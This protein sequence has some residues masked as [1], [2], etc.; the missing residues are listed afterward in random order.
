MY[1]MVYAPYGRSG[2]YMIQDYCRKLGVGTSKEE[3]DA[4]TVMLKNLPQ[5]HPLVAMFRGAREAL[6]ADALI[7]ALLNP[8]DRAYSVP[9]L[10][11]FLDRN[12]LKLGRWYWQ[13]AYL[14]QCGTFGETP[15]APRVAALPEHEQYAVMELWRG[16][17]TIHSLVVHRKDMSGDNKVCFDDEQYLKYL[18]IRLPWTI[19]VQD[20]LPPGAAGALVNQTHVFSDLFVMLDAP[21]K[22]LFDAIDGR[23]TIAEIIEAVPGSSGFAR[24]FFEKLW[25]NDQVVFDTRYTATKRHKRHK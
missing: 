21:E 3:I 18:P 4:L 6:E 25:W 9:E 1:L 23:R 7:D 10:L 20:R 14:P 11:A 16:L 19:C 15:H 2:A 17:M 5:H 12:D 24:K 13:A 22:Q 8:R